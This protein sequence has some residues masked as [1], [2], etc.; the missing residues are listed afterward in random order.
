MIDEA[1]KYAEDRGYTDQME[2]LLNMKHGADYNQKPVKCSLENYT[3]EQIDELL[4]KSSMVMQNQDM[5]N[6]IELISVWQNILEIHDKTKE[7][8]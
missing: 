1:Y 4:D 2:L 3:I 6:Q 8:Q 7:R 5:S